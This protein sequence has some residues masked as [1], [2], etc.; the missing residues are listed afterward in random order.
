MDR[1]GPET[2]ENNKR[3]SISR[4]FYQ[5]FLNIFIYDND[6]DHTQL[7][8]LKSEEEEESLYE[9]KTHTAVNTVSE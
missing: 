9:E 8:L 5:L 1:T 4:E 3:N 7:R 2:I 6:D